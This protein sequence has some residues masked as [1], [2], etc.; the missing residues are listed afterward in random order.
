MK[1][2]GIYAGILDIY[3]LAQERGKD[4]VLLSYD[5]KEQ[6][7]LRSVHQILSEVCPDICSVSREIDV[8][9]ENTWCVIL[10]HATF[11]RL[12]EMTLN[13]WLPA[14]SMLQF[15][16]ADWQ[17]MTLTAEQ[18]MIERKTDVNFALVEAMGDGPK[19]DTEQWRL[20]ALLAA[21]VI[22]DSQDR[23]FHQNYIL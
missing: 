5:D 10:C 11:K 13:H 18:N 4:L 21:S 3:I 1:Q 22:C 20:D 19:Q 17:V 23:S 6:L 16:P 15:D 8:S 2:R 9:S 7:V 14:W 12:S